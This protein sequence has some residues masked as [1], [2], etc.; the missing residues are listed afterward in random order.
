MADSEGIYQVGHEFHGPDGQGYRLKR[1]LGPLDWRGPLPS[2]AFEA[3]GGAP[4][5]LPAVA[6]PEWLL[7]QMHHHIPA[8]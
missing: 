5:P 8:S 3:F 6:I 4:E 1:D 7:V 2:A